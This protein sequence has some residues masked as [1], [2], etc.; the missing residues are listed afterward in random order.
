VNTV[1]ILSPTFQVDLRK[2]LSGW[3]APKVQ[4]IDDMFHVAG[5]ERG[6]DPVDPSGSMGAREKTA[7]RYLDTID[8]ADEE[9]VG[10]I[11]QAV[12]VALFGE[13]LSSEQKEKLRSLCVKEKLIVGDDSVTLPGEKLRK[14]TAAPP[15]R[16][17]PV[18]EFEIFISWSKTASHQAAVAFKDWL[19]GVVNGVEPW[20][21]SQDIEKGT[22]WFKS[23]SEQLSRSRACI[24]LITPENIKS[25]WLYYEAGAVRHAMGDDALICAYLL[26]VEP[27]ALSGGPLGQY[28]MTK[29]EKEDTWLL[30]KT[31]NGRL[32]TPHNEA[33]LRNG[34]DGKW[35]SLRTKLTK[36][37]EKL[38]PASS[39]PDKLDNPDGSD[40]SEEAKHILKE[41][42]QDSLGTVTMRKT[43]R[44]FDLIAHGQQLVDG[45]N[46]RVEAAYREAVNHL[47]SSKFLEPRGDTGG[48]F[49]LTKKGWALADKLRGAAPA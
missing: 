47:V 43:M 42:A 33:M 19:K 37:V 16:R 29:F 41:A 36:V 25:E 18:E 31:L 34:F 6:S 35:Q 26:E 39:S 3:E 9:D 21:S 1:P 12:S 30:V 4:E 24:L 46:P 17:P 7:R 13:W 40:L 14:T 10:K 20:V 27:G 22:S 32:S 45:N 44:G 28:Q 5:I 23:I 11:L 49:G 38:R 15:K 48:N 8:W 2:F